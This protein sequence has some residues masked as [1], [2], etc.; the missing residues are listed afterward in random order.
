MTTKNAILAV[1]ALAGLA[2][3]PLPGSAQESFKV[4]VDVNDNL[5][6]ALDF[7]G[8]R[9]SSMTARLV[10][11]A[12]DSTKI[13]NG[14][15]ETSKLIYRGEG[16]L[17]DLIIGTAAATNFCVA[18]DD[19]NEVDTYSANLPHLTAPTFANTTNAQHANTGASGPPMRPVHFYEGLSI[20]CFG[21]G[22]NLPLVIP[23]WRSY[24]E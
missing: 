1:L 3:M 20:S 9:V 24:K 7:V 17:V 15:A 13:F 5:A 8:A 4:P 12:I 22:N 6:P 21:P 14:T 23:L 18:F 19:D 2:L 11:G 16:V 10:G